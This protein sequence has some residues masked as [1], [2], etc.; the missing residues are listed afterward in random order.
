[1][2]YPQKYPQKEM[3]IMKYPQELHTGLRGGGPEALNYEKDMIFFWR[4]KVMK[5]KLSL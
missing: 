2:K 3:T 1:M 5:K 4:K